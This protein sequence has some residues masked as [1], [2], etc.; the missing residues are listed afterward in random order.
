MG[1]EEMLLGAVGIGLFSTMLY[2]NLVIMN[3]FQEHEELSLAMFFLDARGPLMFQLVVSATI[4][5]S[6]G[7]LYAALAI[8]YH[9]PFLDSYS[10]ITSILLFIVF[11]V[12][13]RHVAYI[14]SKRRAEAGD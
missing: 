14:T 2:Y 3:N 11:T 7:M 4:I 6:L 9:E 13:M 5:Y 12:F 1:F 10:K 8:P